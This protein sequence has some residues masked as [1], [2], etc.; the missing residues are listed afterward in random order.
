MTL[1]KEVT[2]T[3]GKKFLYPFSVYCY[4]SLISSFQQLLLL[5]HFFS[6]CQAWRNRST[7]SGVIEDIYNGQVWKDFQHVSGVEFLASNFA[8]AF[9]INIDWFQPFLHTTYSV[10]VVYL[11]VMN[12]PRHL[13]LKRQ[14]VIIIGVISGPSDPKHD[15]NSFLTTSGEVLHFKSKLPV[16]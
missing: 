8:F 1:L 15:I 11:S 4:R 3:S 6:E 2:G 13:R 9:M 14:N 16:A 12:L 10:G 5:P 7:S